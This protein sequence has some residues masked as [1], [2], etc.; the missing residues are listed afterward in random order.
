MGKRPELKNLFE[1][2]AALK[3]EGEEEV[4]EK[5]EPGESAEPKESS[6]E[7]AEEKAQ[8]PE[9]PDPFVESLSAVLEEMT[10]QEAA[11]AK[12]EQELGMAAEPELEKKEVSNTPERTESETP[13]EDKK[14]TGKEIEEDK[15]EEAEEKEAKLALIKQLVTGEITH[16][17]VEKIATLVTYSTLQELVS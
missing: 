16:P 10:Q 9:E 14:E 15:K 17:D 4:Q 5:E 1:K 12:L 6:D 13:E 2:I 3:K 7:G 11:L 8:K